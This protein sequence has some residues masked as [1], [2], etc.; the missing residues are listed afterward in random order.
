[1]VNLGIPKGEAKK[2]SWYPISRSKKGAIMSGTYNDD[3]SMFPE[4]FH[5]RIRDLHKRVSKIWAC[6]KVLLD[7]KKELLIN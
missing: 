2:P 1:M 5:E 7:K 3:F 6:E 4:C